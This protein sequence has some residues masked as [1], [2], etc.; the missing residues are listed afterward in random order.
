MRLAGVIGKGETPDSD[1]SA[2]G[3]T[4]L[5]AMLDSWRLER[6]MVYQIVQGSYTWASST[7]SR[8]I[9]SGGNFNASRP[10][11]IESAFFRDSSSNDYELAVLRTREEYDSITIKSTTGTQPQWLF[12]DPAYPLGVLY[13]YPISTAQWTLLL[14]TWQSLQ[15]FSALTTDLALPPGYERAIAYGLAMEI[16]PEYG[17]GQ[18]MDPQVP[19]IAIQSKAAIKTVNQPSMVA[20]IEAPGCGGGIYNIYTDS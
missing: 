8:T 19:L 5:N 2:D 17:S 13:A 14:N 6:L 15:S 20:Q 9:G 18:K 4:A 7:T 11:R 3:L 16:A 1:E 12:Y 10:V